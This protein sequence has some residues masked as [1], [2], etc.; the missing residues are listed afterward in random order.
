[1]LRLERGKATALLERERRRARDTPGTT[2]F[3]SDLDPDV[4]RVLTQ[5]KVID[6]LRSRRG[7]ALARGD[8]EIE[9]CEGRSAEV[10]LPEKPDGIRL[11]IPVR[12][13]LWGR[14]EFALYVAP[15]DPLDCSVFGLSVPLMVST[16]DQGPGSVLAGQPVDLHAFRTEVSIPPSFVDLALGFGITT[17]SGT[18]TTLDFDATNATPTTV[19]AAS[20]PMNFGPVPLTEGQPA[21][22]M[23]PPTPAT[24]GPWIAGDGGTIDFTPGSIDLTVLLPISCEPSAPAPTLGT[25]VIR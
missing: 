23:V 1:M 22:F 13:T 14:I 20:S 11:A 3:V 15:P 18:V 16:F 5:R 4:L 10:V 12:Q 21:T 19:N 24:V 2:V 8:Y 6:Y 25:T 17:L 9:V 7:P